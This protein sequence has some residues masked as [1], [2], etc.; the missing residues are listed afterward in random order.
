VCK[1]LKSFEEGKRGRQEV[2]MG[3]E[4]EDQEGN[5]RERV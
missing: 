3:E 5:W 2:K 1:N 4:E